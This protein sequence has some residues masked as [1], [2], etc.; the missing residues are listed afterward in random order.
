[1]ASV[2]QTSEI[3]DMAAWL[4]GRARIESEVCGDSRPNSFDEAAD[5]LEAWAA[6]ISQCRAAGFLDENGAVRK[7]LGTFQLTTDGAIACEE[8]PCWC[9]YRHSEDHPSHISACRRSGRPDNYGCWWQVDGCDEEYVEIL[10][11]WSTK[12]AAAAASSA[13]KEP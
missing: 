3:T 1:M 8:G 2:L 4:R 7:V 11:T 9:V 13:R 10:S 12:E 5:T 6:T